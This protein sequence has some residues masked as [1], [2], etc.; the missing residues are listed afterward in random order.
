MMANR[1]SIGILAGV[2]IFSLDLE[3][4]YMLQNPE[5]SARTTLASI[6]DSVIWFHSFTRAGHRKPRAHFVRLITIAPDEEPNDVLTPGG[7]CAQRLFLSRLL[8]VLQTEGV[9]PVLIDKYF[10]E[11]CPA[12]A[13][14][15]I[16]L[17]NAIQ[18]VSQST[19]IIIGLHANTS[20]ELAVRRKG[21]LSRDERH[22]FERAQLMLEPHNEVY[23]GPNVAYGLLTLDEGTNRI[24]ASW[25]VFDPATQQFRSLNT[26]SMLTAEAYDKSSSA[27]AQFSEFQHRAKTEDPYTNF[28]SASE[29]PTLSAIGVLCNGRPVVGSEW[30]QCEGGSFG[31]QLLRNHVAVIGEYTD[32]DVHDSALGTVYGPLLQANYT[33]SILDDRYFWP[34]CRPLEFLIG[35]AWWGIVFL[36][37]ERSSSIFRA[38]LYSVGISAVLW[39]ALFDFAM[40][41][42]GVYM[43]I[44]APGLMVFVGRLGDQGWRRIKGGES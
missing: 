18:Q 4:E 37:V 22:I 29:F 6:A 16:A 42:W 12:D 15:T 26:V 43:T 11:R 2:L 9:G 14:E 7:Y 3:K 13:P 24:P 39:V 20:E 40:Q 21:K 10:G 8:L 23:E 41:Q 44:G 36:I 28:V 17:R 5:P 38:F 19:P 27:K 1:K 34:V 35:L 31:Q 30:R 33:E 32:L 25:E